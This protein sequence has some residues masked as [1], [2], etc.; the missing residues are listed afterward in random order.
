MEFIEFIKLLLNIKSP[1]NLPNLGE[2]DLGKMI[3]GDCKDEKD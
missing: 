3:E 2:V 1:S